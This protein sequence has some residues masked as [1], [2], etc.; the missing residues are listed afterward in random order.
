[1]LLRPWQKVDSVSNED[2]IMLLGLTFIMWYCLLHNRQHHLS[3]VT[4][5]LDLPIFIS[6]IIYCRSTSIVW[7][8]KLQVMCSGCSYVGLPDV[9]ENQEYPDF[10]LLSQLPEKVQPGQP[11]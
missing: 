8:F 3:S 6:A 5:V 9:P 10:G 1:M 4:P 11:V 7:I 2:W